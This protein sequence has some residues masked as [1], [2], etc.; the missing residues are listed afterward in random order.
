[1]SGDGPAATIAD[2]FRR[3][4]VAE[5]EIAAAKQE[6]PLL[7]PIID[8]A[9][10]HVVPTEPLARLPDELYRLLGSRVDRRRRP[11]RYLKACVFR[12]SPASS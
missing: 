6:T 12:S 3:L 11:L 7:A 9:F 1:M 2:M 8:D 4:E 10:R 5:D